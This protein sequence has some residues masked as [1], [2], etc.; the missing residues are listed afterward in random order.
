[1]KVAMERKSAVL[2]SNAIHH[3]VDSL[4]GIAA[5]VSIA[6]SN[7]FPTLAG[8]DAFGG[9]MI[10]Y[11][12]IR[13][14]W[15]NTITSLQELADTAI[16]DEIKKKTQTEAERA[17]RDCNISGAEINNVSGTKAGQNYLLDVTVAVPSECTIQETAGAEKVIRERIASKVR[18][19]RRI[20]VKFVSVE[21]G[22]NAMDEFVTPLNSAPSSPEPENS[23]HNH[24]HHHYHNG[25]GG[26]T[27]AIKRT[28]HGT[29]TNVSID[30][31]KQP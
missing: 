20:R 11:M 15:G 16:S 26:S 10:S 19:A 2:T 9:L 31:R 23:D 18:G 12:V 17:I 1:M 28:C 13:A 30:K 6:L 22:F 24:H 25:N 14:G 8:M 21:D 27:T 4:T 29:T 3:R 7:I 5:L